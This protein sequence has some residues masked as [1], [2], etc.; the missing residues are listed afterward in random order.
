[1]VLFTTDHAS[2]YLDKKSSLGTYICSA[3]TVPWT[4]LTR[5]KGRADY[6][7]LQAGVCCILTA[8]GRAAS[9]RTVLNIDVTSRLSLSG[10]KCS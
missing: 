4:L 5:V 6:D 10:N 8:R 9:R 7:R 3:Y 2:S 1:M